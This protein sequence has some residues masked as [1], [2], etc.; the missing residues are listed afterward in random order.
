M[1]RVQAEQ[2]NTERRR[3]LRAGKRQAIATL[4]FESAEQLDHQF[5]EQK[6]TEIKDLT[7]QITDD[8]IRD[9]TTWAT[10]TKKKVKEIVQSGQQSNRAASLKYHRLFTDLKQ[11]QLA[12]LSHLET[13]YADSR[14]RE[15]D[16]RNPEQ[17]AML[18]EA[19]QLAIQGLYD[20][21]RKVR[22]RSRE[23]GQRELET[24]L[25]DLEAKFNRERSELLEAHAEALHALNGRFVE[26][27][28]LVSRQTDDA[29]Q[30][31]NALRDEKVKELYE[32]TRA[33]IPA[34]MEKGA[35][36]AKSEQD[37]W[38]RLDS[39]CSKLSFANPVP[40]P[41]ELARAEADKKTAA[42]T[43]IRQSI[44]RSEASA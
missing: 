29:V 26:E 33:K 44:S 39:E 1:S 27:V 7:H 6:L 28:D 41:A 17:I 13:Q 43:R 40:N 22:D 37:L 4:D 30:R 2:A 25:R 21:A 38:T 19:K 36:G 14:L 15:N 8:F 9:V 18:E 16:R 24:R 31:Q 42:H 23:C 5:K 12:A 34:C 3:T 35:R 11:Q 10:K 20:K 32:T